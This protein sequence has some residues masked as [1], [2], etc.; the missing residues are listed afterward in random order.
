MSALFDSDSKVN[1]I[2]PT[3]AKE[4]SLSIR[5]TD[6]KVQKINGTTLD[7]Y[8][9]IIVA[10]SMMD[11]AN[12]VR[13]LKQTFLLA[14]VSL[15]VVFEMPFFILSDV[16]VDFS[17]RELWWKTY[18]IK[19]AF[20]TTKRI[21]VVGKKKFAAAALDPKYE[22]YVVH[23]GLVSSVILPSSFPLELDVYTSCKPQISSLIAKKAPIKVSAKYLDFINIFSL[24]LASEFLKQTGINNY[25][26][27][28][29]DG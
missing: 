13:F 6:I 10:F 17:S 11:K 25:A 20:S 28:L 19:K 12:Q 26:L 7:T 18:T 2:Y 27:E 22:T 9:M 24:D 8:K 3:F 21:E 15:E 16:D 23:V 29:V 4:Q 1:V 14:N 5:P